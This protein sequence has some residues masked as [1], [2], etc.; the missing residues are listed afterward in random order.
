MKTRRLFLKSI[1]VFTATA[2]FPNLAGAAR[3]KDVGR[4]AHDLAATLKAAHGGAWNIKVDYD[5]VLISR[6]K[7]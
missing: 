1:P 7:T 2:A 5:F 4:Q 6:K 3:A